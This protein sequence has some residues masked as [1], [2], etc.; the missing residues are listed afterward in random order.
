[1][2][3]GAPLPSDSFIR[4]FRIGRASYVAD[5]LE[6]A[7]LL[8]QDMAELRN[9]K[10][11]EVLLTLKR[12]LALVIS[13]SQAPNPHLYFFFHFL[14]RFKK[15]EKLLSSFLFLCRIQVARAS[16]VVKE[17]VNHALSKSKEE[18]SCRISHQ[19][20]G[21]KQEEAEGSTL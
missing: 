11:H 8:P 7:L 12:D 13:H 20:L 2:L 4:D 9:L 15:K 18:G 5:S 17:W 16:H 14:L 19:G 10:K 6:Q 3:D 1:M 21:F